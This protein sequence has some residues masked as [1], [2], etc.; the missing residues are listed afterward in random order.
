MTKMLA[1]LSLTCLVVLLWGCGGE[2]TA[3]TPPPPPEPDNTWRGLVVE[4]ENACSEYNRDRDYG[5]TPASLEAQIV[6]RMGGRIY[7]P[8]TGTYFE[9]TSETDMEHMIALREAHDSGACAWS[10]DQ[11]R[12]FARDLDNLTLASPSVNRNQK[13]DKDA[14]DWLPPYEPNR[15]WFAAQV[16]AVRRKYS[17]T[18]DRREADALEGVLASCSST[19][20]VFAAP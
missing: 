13:S 10:S 2:S 15:C 20:L 12:T 14:A 11:K 3:P 4:A 7:G 16:V 1:S 17:L 18:V 8:Y 9:S 5:R 19:S 6:E